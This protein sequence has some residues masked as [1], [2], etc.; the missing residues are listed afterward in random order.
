[1]PKISGTSRRALRWRMKPRA[2]I[3]ASMKLAATPEMRNSRLRR[4]G[5]ESIMN[6]SIASLASGLLTCQSQVT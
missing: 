3:L 6:G 4:H 5:D 2:P 1:M